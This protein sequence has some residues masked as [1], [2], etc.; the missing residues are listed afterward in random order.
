MKS[1][2]DLSK[3]EQ[4]QLKKEFKMKYKRIDLRIPLYAISILFAILCIPSITGI[5]VGMS[6]NLEEYY[7]SLRIDS[8][9]FIIFLL[10]AIINSLK[11]SNWDKQF[12]SWLKTKNILK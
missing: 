8:I 4:T 7:I 5:L 6:D 1:W 11:L 9:L 10:L 3:E 2:F 12:I